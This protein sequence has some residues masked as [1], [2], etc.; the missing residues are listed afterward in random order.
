[1]D[2][3]KDKQDNLVKG[4]REMYKAMDAIQRGE[5]DPAYKKTKEYKKYKE[6]ADYYDY[7]DSFDTNRKYA[8]ID[9][10][11]ATINRQRL[12]DTIHDSWVNDMSLRQAMLFNEQHMR[13]VQTAIAMHENI[14]NMHIDQ[15]NMMNHQQFMGMM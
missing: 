9:V 8:L 3:I 12:E 15:V 11:K 7:Y 10:G 6:I 2:R 14:M 1:M 5:K 13:D 4:S